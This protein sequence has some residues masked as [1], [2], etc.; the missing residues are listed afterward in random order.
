MVG[1]TLRIAEAIGGIDAEIAANMADVS[2]SIDG[3][4]IG[5]ATI[6]YANRR[7]GAV[8][9]NCVETNDFND[10]TNTAIDSLL[11]KR[12]KSKFSTKGKKYPDRGYRFGLSDSQK[13]EISEYIEKAHAQFKT[14]FLAGEIQIKT[15]MVGCE[16][17]HLVLSI[18]ETQY[19]YGLKLWDLFYYLME[20]TYHLYEYANWGKE[21]SEGVDVTQEVLV[22]IGGMEAKKDAFRQKIRSGK[23]VVALNRCWECGTTKILGEYDE[24]HNLKRMPTD[25]WARAEKERVA[26]TSRSIKGHENEILSSVGFKPS[27]DDEFE[28][29]IVSDEYDGC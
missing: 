17:P 25:L 20:E 1:I 21:R 19:D 27:A 9:I 24:N 16:Y 10:E 26:A 2:L 3:N 15:K 28:F 8:V 22:R 7:P 29:V 13:K 6:S 23:H 14:D 5:R 11:V 4:P 18:D 12:G